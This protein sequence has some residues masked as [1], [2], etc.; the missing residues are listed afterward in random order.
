MTPS[1]WIWSG[2]V[3]STEHIGGIS[4]T[5]AIFSHLL[6]DPFRVW[7]HLIYLYK[8]EVAFVCAVYTVYVHFEL[9]TKELGMGGV[10]FGIPTAR[11]SNW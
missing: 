8:G 10:M 5:D 9:L 6:K 3:C 1:D 7:N 4:F 2:S 11:H